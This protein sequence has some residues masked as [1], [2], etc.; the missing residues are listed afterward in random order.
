MDVKL[1][2]EVSLARFIYVN[3]FMTS[4]IWLI[5]VALEQSTFHYIDIAS[6]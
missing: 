4:Q 3:C 5:Y 2:A 6:C 1:I